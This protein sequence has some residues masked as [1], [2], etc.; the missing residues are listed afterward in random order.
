[1]SYSGITT[2]TVNLIHLL[3]YR[4]DLSP[5][6]VI[7]IV[8]GYKKFAWSRSYGINKTYRFYHHPLLRA[9]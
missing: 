3:E 8:L 6:F 4:M 7:L 9:K 2:V 1:M 5:F